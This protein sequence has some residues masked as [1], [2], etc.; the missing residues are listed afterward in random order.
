VTLRLS[1]AIGSYPHTAPLKDGR[2][3]SNRLK[4]DHVEITPV[5]RAFRPMVNELIY[6][7][8]EMAL[9]T[10]MLARAMGRPL[11]GIAV[12]LLRQ[13]AHAL[14]GVRA[15][16]PAVGPRD[17]EGRRIG[18]R[19]YTQTTGTWVRGI[20]QHQFGVDLAKLAWLTFED[21]HVDGYVD[22]PNCTRAPDGL[23]LAAALER[24]EV[25]AAIGLE[26]NP[27]WRP[28]LPDVADAERAFEEQT[29]VRPINHVFVVKKQL[30][31]ANPW[32]TQEL[33]DVVATS[34]NLTSSDNPRGL[35]ALRPGVE[36]LSKFAQ[37]QGI[38]PRQVTAKE[39]FPV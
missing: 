12:V 27:S 24:G 26:P 21:A 36:L 6:D 18:V 1:T 11:R 7:V 2:V 13:S 22:P 31:E 23:T 20:L 9:V 17:L 33:F 25:D 30:A 28:L 38:I 35:E 8:S 15:D 39:L 16:A 10:L 3:T 37:E 32:L 5:N 34:L 4:L 19:A 29:G 14:L